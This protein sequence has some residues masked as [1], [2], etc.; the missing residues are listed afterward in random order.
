MTG[1]TFSL[2]KGKVKFRVFILFPQELLEGGLV[3]SLV[4]K[5]KAISDDTYLYSE[6]AEEMGD[7]GE[8]ITEIH[9]CTHSHTL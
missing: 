4:V 3:F 2:D 9:P 7:K 5:G 8:E 1:A 6:V